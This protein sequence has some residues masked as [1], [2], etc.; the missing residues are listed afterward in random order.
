M[1]EPVWMEKYAAVCLATGTIQS[2]LFPGK[3]KLFSFYMYMQL[4]TWLQEPFIMLF[5]GKLKLFSFY[6]YMHLSAWLQEPFTPIY[7]WANL[8]Y[9]FLH[10]HEAVYLALGTIQSNYY[11]L[12][13]T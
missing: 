5:L 8:N 12:T 7:S 9:S 13:S 3:L 2:N 11:V 10:V 1:V 6:M 4:S